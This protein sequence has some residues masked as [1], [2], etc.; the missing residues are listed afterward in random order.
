MVTLSDSVQRLFDGKNF[1]VLSTLEPDGRPHSTVVWTKRDGD[2]IVFALPKNRRKTK[3]LIRHPM[4]TV[5]IFDTTNPYESA[6]V[7]GT[8]TIQD[9]PDAL[10]VEELSFK[11][12]GG[13]YPGFAGPNP[14]WVTARITPD[15]VTTSWPDP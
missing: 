10:L 5:V 8:A 1:A 7:Q 15:K 11:Y 9:D 6:Q 4:A 12:T 3:N 13:P 14:Q 2:D